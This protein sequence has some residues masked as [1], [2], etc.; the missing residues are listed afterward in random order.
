MTF[1]R[2]L[3]QLTLLVAV[4]L[5]FFTALPSDARPV[6]NRLRLL[7]WNIQN[8]MWDGQNDN[9]DRF[10]EFVRS[11]D[12]DICV[13]CEARTN[14][15]RDTAKAMDPKGVYLPDNWGLL[16]SRYGHR[17]W[18]IGEYR[19]RF[20]QVIT[21]RYPI[22]N[23][24]R[25][26]GAEP[27]SVVA[28]GCGWARINYAGNV[29][30]LVT[31]HTWPQKYGYDVP[32][33]ERK[34]DAARCG[35]DRY[36]RKE[37]EYICRHTILTSANAEKENW[38]M[39]GDFNAVSRVDSGAY[40]FASDSPAYL[41]HDYIAENT[42]YK[43]VVAMT[44]KG[45]FVP[46]TLSGRRID[47][48]YCTAPVMDRVLSAEILRNSYTE[49]HRDKYAGHNF[50][51]PS[52]HLPILV[53]FDFSVRC[54]IKIGRDRLDSFDVAGPQDD[55]AASGAVR[56]LRALVMDATGVKL[57][58]AVTDEGRGH[59]LIFREG[60]PDD[61]SVKVSDGNVIISGGDEWSLHNAVQVFVDD[62]ST[63]SL[64]AS[65]SKTGSVAGL[66]LFPLQEGCNLRILDD[67]I[68][69]YSR[70][71]IPPAWKSLGADCRDEVRSRGFA[72]LVRAYMP[73]VFTVQEYSEHMHSYLYPLLKQ[74]GYEIADTGSGGNWNNT[75][76]YYL[77]EKLEL[78]YDNYVLYTPSMWSNHGSKSYT[79]AVFTHRE[80]GKDF[81]VLNTHLW[82]KSD[83]V[84]P[85]STAARV[86]QVNLMIAEGNT[87]RDKYKCPIFVTGD[88]NCEENTP[89]I[90]QLLSAGYVPCYRAATV[91]GNQD[92]GHHICSPTEGFSTVSRRKGPERGKGAIDHCFIYDAGCAEVRVFDCIQAGFT[93]PLTDHYPNLIDIVI[94]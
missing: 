64:A 52:D 74:Y 44:R 82:W 79:A 12:P 28:H 3:K 16:A 53:D 1:N 87:I 73:E 60:A 4:G 84:K 38:L 10:V 25:I 69:D 40:D 72:R 21:S 57:P 37:M 90:R 9:Y 75:P 42:P 89:P 13:W 41:T 33:S 35:G 58:D 91:Y 14:Y 26:A 56:E 8:G 65:Y 31:V 32:E 7:Y 17:Y 43:D 83:M 78:K 2:I 71:T 66:R 11:Q 63:G 19:D 86:A 6:N 59:V 18:Y 47:F 55:A 68:W 5:T 22:E 39:M 45:E 50:C 27:D 34:A 88:M 30:N 61:W 93:V 70:D 48:V 76:I 92:N 24:A 94:K 80:T 67:N 49:P 85:G 36:R 15:Q 29:L 81:A 23:V 77:P 51:R 46:S 62:L 54:G 20:P